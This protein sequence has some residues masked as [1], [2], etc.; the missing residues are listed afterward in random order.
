VPRHS[1]PQQPSWLRPRL[2]VA[3]VVATAGLVTA[4]WLPTRNDSA[5]A[6]ERNRNSDSRRSSRSLPAF[7]DDFSGRR[8]STVDPGKWTLRTDRDGGVR[9]SE[10][11]RNARLDGNGNL[12]IVV[13][14]GD[15]DDATTARL[16]TRGTLRGTAGRVEARIKAP[17]G[18]GL[19]PVF[20]LVSAAKPGSDKLNVLAEPV[21]DDDFHTYA[22]EFKPGEI[23]LSVDGVQVSRETRD[24]LDTGQPFRLALSLVLDDDGREQADLPARMSVDSVSFSGADASAEPTTPPATVPTK[25]PATQPTATTPPATTPPATPPTSEPPTVAPTTTPPATTKP[26]TTPPTTAPAAKAWAPFTDY[27]AGQLVTFKG[28]EYQV[29]E[30]HTSLPGWE[31]TALPA[32]FKKI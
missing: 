12:V 24:G 18:R 7:A 4:V 11:V 17:G 5:D 30:T 3:F 13:R 27:I 1:A 10:S 21:T 25:P 28:V 32:L 15:D 9:F 19:R 31:P 16:Y 29:L 23:T 26:P 22:A 14:G 6:A 8:G 20:E 2:V